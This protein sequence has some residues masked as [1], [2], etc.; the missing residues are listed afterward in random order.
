MFWQ[1]FLVLSDIFPGV[2]PVPFKFKGKH[3]QEQI[4]HLFN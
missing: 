2:W 4:Q 3:S 1:L